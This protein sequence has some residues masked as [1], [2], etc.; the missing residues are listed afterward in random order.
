[1]A[2]NVQFA[3]PLTPAQLSWLASVAIP[4]SQTPQSGP[5][6]PMH[7]S[8]EVSDA[9]SKKSLAAKDTSVQNIQ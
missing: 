2:H 4:S 9:H 7:A 1:M 3:T 6:S 8:P 5:H